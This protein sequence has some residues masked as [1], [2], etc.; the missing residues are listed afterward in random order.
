MENKNKYNSAARKKSKLQKNK[1]SGFGG[2]QSRRSSSSTKP[3]V[4]SLTQLLSR[5]GKNRSN[6]T[7]SLLGNNNSTG[8]N[9]RSAVIESLDGTVKSGPSV[10]VASTKKSVNASELTTSTNKQDNRNFA[11]RNNVSNVTNARDAQNKQA[12]SSSN[13]LGASSGGTRTGKTGKAFTSAMNSVGSRVGATFGSSRSEI[14]EGNSSNPYGKNVFG[15]SYLQNASA[16]GGKRLQTRTG[17]SRGLDRDDQS[18]FQSGIALKPIIPPK[19]LII[20]LKEKP[21]KI[22][23]NR[24]IIDYKHCGLLQ[25]YIGLG[26][27]ILPRRQTRLTA[28]Q[29]RYIAKT[30]KTA[31]IMGLLPFVSKEKSYFK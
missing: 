24:R 17:A 1:K 26:G 7:Y 13:T 9:N 31:R 2:Q 12:F 16:A 25:R 5:A 10:G 3:G 18:G 23:Y 29:Q 30:I 28:R 11:L 8:K 22:L 19:S 21:E 27:K 15:G 6:G 4:L 20:I 14:R